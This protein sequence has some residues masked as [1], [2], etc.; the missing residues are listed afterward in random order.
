MERRVPGADGVVTLDDVPFQG[1]WV[2]RA[3]EGP[4]PD[5][6]SRREAPRFSSWALSGS[7]AVTK[8]ILVSFFSS[9]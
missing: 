7:L 9:A 3:A 4:S 5:Y 2:R 1:T 8:E 6:N